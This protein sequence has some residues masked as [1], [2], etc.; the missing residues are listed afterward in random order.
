MKILPETVATWITILGFPTA[1]IAG[2]LGYVQLRDYFIQP[3][4]RMEFRQN[5]EVLPNLSLSPNAIDYVIIN[6]SNRTAEDPYYGFILYDVDDPLSILPI[7]FATGDF[8]KSGEQLGYNQ[9]TEK[10]A[11]P[12]HRYFGAAMITCRN[13]ASVKRYFVYI[14][15]D[16]IDNGFYFLLNGNGQEQLQEFHDAKGDLNIFPVDQRIKFNTP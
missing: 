10:Y 2:F 12:G 15:I 6:N 13:C 5:T 7:P 4:L 9:L 8:I 14:D 1:I 11:K 16:H 3:D